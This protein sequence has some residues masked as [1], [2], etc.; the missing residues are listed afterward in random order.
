ME[1]IW[2]PDEAEELEGWHA[3]REE[4]VLIERKHLEIRVALRDAEAAL[5]DDPGNEN[6]RARVKYLQK[7][8]KGLERQ[9]PWIASDIAMEVFL[10]GGPYGC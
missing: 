7:R 6:L 9:A 1:G 8:L 10:W 4:T 2:F 3:F 5:R